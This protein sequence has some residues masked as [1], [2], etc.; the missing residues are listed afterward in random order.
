MATL[1]NITKL[2]LFA[3]VL[4]QPAHA[5]NCYLLI[6]AQGKTIYHAEKPPFDMSYP[7]FSDEYEAS[8]ARGERLVNTGEHCF[9]KKPAPQQPKQD[10]SAQSE[11]ARPAVGSEAKD[12]T[13]PSAQLSE[14]EMGASIEMPSYSP[15]AAPSK[16]NIPGQPSTVTKAYKNPLPST[17]YKCVK[18]SRIVYVLDLPG[19]DGQCQ[20]VALHDDRPS[21]AELARVLEEE[22]LRE[23]ERER[24]REK[25]LEEKARVREEVERQAENRRQ[26]E[27]RE[28]EQRERKAQ[29]S[30]SSSSA[31]N[32]KKLRDCDGGMG[33]HLCSDPNASA[34]TTFTLPGSG[35]GVRS[36]SS[37]R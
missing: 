33:L 14:S 15:S 28:H 16:Q 20:A 30:S 4:A 36:F 24:E 31:E 32:E 2:L 6:N 1:G 27:Q 5:V 7:P 26:A 10:P 11:T 21:P 3:C 34:P 17:A 19:T 12:A 9:F 18:D 23:I 13:Q 35:G 37:G 22:R 25:E 29:S 8:R